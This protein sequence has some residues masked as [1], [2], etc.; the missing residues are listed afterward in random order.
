MRSAP[1]SL[2]HLNNEQAAGERFG[3]FTLAGGRVELGVTFEI[4]SLVPLP[5]HPL[6][7]VRVVQEVGSLLSAPPSVSLIPLEL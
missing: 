1:H 6:C 4:E 7:F 2:G 5:A 3:L